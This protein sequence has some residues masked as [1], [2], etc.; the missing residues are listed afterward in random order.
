MTDK[1]GCADGLL[2][3]KVAIITG[4]ASGIGRASALRFAREGAR[5]AIWDCN[6]VRLEETVAALE[7]G[8]RDV[9]GVVANVASAEDVKAG[10]E[11]TVQAFGRLDILFN[12]AGV[13]GWGLLHEMPEA[14]WD[15]V[16]DVNLKGVFLCSKY[17]LP[18]LMERGGVILNTASTAG[19]EGLP[20]H[21]HYCAAKAGV[22]NLTRSIAMDYA[23]Y[24]IRA[25]ALCPGGVSTNIAESFVDGL[26]PAAARAV[27]ENA[28]RTDHSLSL[29]G[30]RG[31]AEELAAA[32]LF[33]CSAEASY[34]TGQTLVVDG[35]WLAGHRPEMAAAALRR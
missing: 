25:N 26:P 7:S 33:L 13:S 34:V 15:R 18:A 21:G 16:V 14:E 24:G 27:Q 3:G 4:G 28:K 30:R 10:V 9:I 5:V 11:K 31:T 23:A 17:S 1:A 19:L 35:G 29:M 32:A 6:S 8:V 20:A 2:A 22:V 12:N